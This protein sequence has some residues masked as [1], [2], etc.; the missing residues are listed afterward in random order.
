MS[1]AAL[2][3]DATLAARSRL[4]TLNTWTDGGNSLSFACDPPQTHPT[5]SRF[6]RR[7]DMVLLIRFAE[8]FRRMYPFSFSLRLSDSFKRQRYRLPLVTN[9]RR[10]E[11]FP[12]HTTCPSAYH[13]RGGRQSGRGYP[14]P[15]WRCTPCTSAAPRRL[16]P[17]ELFPR[18][19]A[20]QGRWHAT[21]I[22]GVKTNRC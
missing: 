17:T 1:L 16:R 2:R 7:R 12:M 6:P 21:R 13:W 14:P 19:R 15:H 4:S 22:D 8:Y 20:Y 10:P 11:R 18:R 5:A 9:Q 3:A